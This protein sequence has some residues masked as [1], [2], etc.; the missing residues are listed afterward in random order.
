MHAG[1][2]VVD[3]V[4]LVLVGLALLVGVLLPRPALIA[5]VIQG[6][7]FFLAFVGAVGVVN[8]FRLHEAGFKSLLL[9]VG[10]FLALLLG[11]GAIFA[12]GIAAESAMQV[13]GALAVAAGVL[14]VVA[15]IALPGREH[16]G[17][18]L[19]NGLLTFA[20]GMVMLFW[21]G[22]AF[23]VMMIFFGVELLFL[24]AHRLRAGLRMRRLAR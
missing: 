17:I 9:F 20:A 18:L 23:M 5:A 19:L 12:P 10:P 14:E 3:G 8:A 24:G 16:W 1:L 6:V 4:L 2:V 7:G 21:P 11:F 15:A 13:F 22:I